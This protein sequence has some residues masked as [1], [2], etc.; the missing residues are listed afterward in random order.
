MS[1]D[2]LVSHPLDETLQA[3]GHHHFGLVTKHRSGF[4]YVGVR[5]ERFGGGGGGVDDAGGFV[6][7]GFEDFDELE[8]FDGVAAT[9]VEDFEGEGAVQGGGEAG[10]DVVDVGP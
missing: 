6:E 5:D 2:L 10:D 1:D 9:Q 4:A 8:V 7:D 3:F